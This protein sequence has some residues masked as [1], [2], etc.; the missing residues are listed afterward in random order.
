MKRITTWIMAAI[1]SCSPVAFTS[2]V[3]GDNPVEKPSKDKKNADRAAIEKVL[4]ERLARTAK[5]ARF[6]SAMKATKTLSDFLSTL[7]E[8]AVK[9]DIGTIVATVIS[10]G[11][12]VEMSSLS[13]PNKQAVEKCLKDQFDMTTYELSTLESFVQI[14]AYE[15]LNK[16]HVTL[17]N[18]QCTYTED[19]EAFTVEI[20][21]SATER[22]KFQ[23]K[24]GD[25]DDDICLFL[26]RVGDTVPLAFQLPKS[27]NVSFTTL[28]GH[29]LN[30]VINLSSTASS[31]YAS[32]KSDDWKVGVKLTETING[33]NETIA[34]QLSYGKDRYTDEYIDSDELKQ[35]SDMGNFF[36]AGYKLMKTNNCKSVEELSVTLDDDIV[37]S[38]SIDDAAKS[39]LALGHLR[40]LY[41]THP[42]FY[43][44]DT[45]T[46]ELNK[47]VHYTV[48]QKSTNITA[49]G[50]LFTILKGSKN[51]FQPGIA[52]TFKGETTSQSMYKNLSEEDLVNYQQIVQNFKDLMDEGTTMVENFS[53]KI[54]TIASAFKI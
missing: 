1:L 4:S 40:Q 36:A 47:Y 12:I 15:T 22:M 27:F 45:Y 51:E 38:V 5:D 13:A 46:Q 6:E 33:R 29:V 10:E 24:F 37:V 31:S 14:D 34:A 28:S 3:S 8:D 11:K 18:N 52:L 9:I 39:L 53:S 41:G 44:V 54:K 42:G 16:F 48:Y 26:T 7:D 17:E 25:S 23:A 21:K 32:M 43:V 50:S 49:K 35:L 2:C 19:A 20:V 30:G